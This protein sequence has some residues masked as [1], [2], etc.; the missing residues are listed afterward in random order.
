MQQV[1][2]VVHL[3]GVLDLAEPYICLCQRFEN[4]YLV[5]V[6]RTFVDVRD[7]NGPCEGL[8]RKVGSPPFELRGAQ[9]F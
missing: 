7:M 5:H 8:L 2:L 9:A 3:A 1:D 6:V 4:F